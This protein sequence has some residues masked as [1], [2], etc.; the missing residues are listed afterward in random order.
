MV[1]DNI[2][3]LPSGILVKKKKKLCFFKILNLGKR[4]GGGEGTKRGN[5][6][7]INGLKRRKN[8]AGPHHIWEVYGRAVCG[9]GAG[10][11]NDVFLLDQTSNSDGFCVYFHQFSVFQ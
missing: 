9:A 6:K 8:Q 3:K 10:G 4:W 1:S 2:T 11:T 7:L 5:P